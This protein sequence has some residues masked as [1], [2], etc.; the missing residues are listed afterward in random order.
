MI[1][2]VQNVSALS[3]T[4]NLGETSSVES[5]ASSLGPAQA[6]AAEAGG[7]SFASVLGGMASDAVNN[8]KGAEAMS[9]EGIKGTANTRQVVDA[10]LQAEQSL[11]TAMAFRDKVVSA[12]L[13]ITKMQ[14]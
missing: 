6:G 3:Q 8:I 9:F 12:Y 14:M 11:Q 13:E 1:D 5:T 10:M 7:M 4:R 2:S